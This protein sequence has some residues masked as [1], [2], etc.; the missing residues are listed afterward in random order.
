MRRLVYAVFLLALPV[1]GYAASAP[2]FPP[3]LLGFD[4]PAALADDPPTTSETS[5]TDTTPTTTDTTPTTTDTTPTTTDTTPTTTDT[6]PTTTDTTPTTTN[7]IST[8]TS[9]STTSTTIPSTTTVPSGEPAP[10]PPPRTTTVAP[11]TTAS[12]TA[13]TPPSVRNLKAVVGD[14]RVTLTYDI[15]DGVDHVVIKRSTPGGPAER[16]YSGTADTFIDRGLTNGTEYRYVVACVN[17][18]GNESAGVAVVLVPRRNLLRA[19]KDGARLRKAPKLVWARTAE[20]SYYNV[21]LMWKGVKILSIWPSKPAYKL[22]KTWKY[23]GRKYQ[24]K[25]GTYQWYVWPGYGPRSQVA[26][27]QML[28]SRSF[29]IVG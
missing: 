13:P 9:S 15:P 10:P 22:N 26:Y 20:A 21:Q 7:T 5:S 3:R 18:A 17:Q 4:R 6:T 8:T 25:A 2:A 11:T 27:G 23:R 24:L 14:G 29:R 16:V 12:P 1:V 19:P 28:G